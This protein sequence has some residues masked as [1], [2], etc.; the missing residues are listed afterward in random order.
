MSK[1]TATSR[2]LAL[3]DSFAYTEENEAL[4][5]EAMGEMVD[6]HRARS[7]IYDGV[8]RQH[9]FDFSR[10]RTGEDLLAIPHIIVSAFKLRKIL[11]LPESEIVFTALSS[12][13]QGTVS[14]LNLDAISLERQAFTRKAI[15][16]TYG[17][18]DYDR[19]VNYIVFNYDPETAG[20]RGAAYSDLRYTDFAPAHDLLWAISRGKDGQPEFKMEACV[21]KLREYERTGLPL[22]LIGFPSF[23]YFTLKHLDEQGVSFRFPPES[24]IIVGG[25]WKLHTGQS[26]PFE[27]YAEVVERVVG[28]PRQRIRD[29]YG[30]VE[31]GIPYITCEHNQFHIPIYS[32]VCTVD[33][34]SLR[35]LPQGE[36]GLLKFITP[37]IRS[38]PSISVLST[39]FGEVH[40]DCP[41]GRKAPYL[42]LKGRGGVQKYAG[43]A[44][45]AAQLLGQ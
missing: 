26:V 22:R 35:V 32:R 21:A 38:Q 31:H 39:D 44:I 17:L 4:F 42:L 12:G 16:E 29:V 1:E 5:F 28:I 41:C 2:L 8:C 19:K 14:Q 43:C 11:S 3:G 45:S 20:Q 27:T 13:T 30:M 34:G 37:Y 18:A 6:F 9:G 10:L 36:K 7:P 24:A 15:I 40:A 23:S 33:P 25:G